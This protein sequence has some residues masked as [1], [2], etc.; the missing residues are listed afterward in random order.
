MSPWLGGPEATIYTLLTCNRKIL[1]TLVN[2][3]HRVCRDVEVESSLQLLGERFYN[4]SSTD[5]NARLDIKANGLWWS[6]LSRTFL[7]VSNGGLHMS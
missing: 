7:D 1:D 6:R 4:K 2:L 3:M 5:D